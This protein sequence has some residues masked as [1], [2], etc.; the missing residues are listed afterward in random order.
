[1]VNGIYQMAYDLFHTY[2]YGGVAMTT[3]MEL[4]TVFLSTLACL[5]VVA[6]P[7]WVVIKITKMIVG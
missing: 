4:T 3:E 1:M 7:F 6:M 2:I 5:F